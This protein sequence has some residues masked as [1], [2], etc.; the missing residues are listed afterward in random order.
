MNTCKKFIPYTVLALICLFN[1]WLALG[2]L[3]N[4]T[5]IS[6]NAKHIHYVCDMFAKIENGASLSEILRTPTYPPVFYINTA[7]WFKLFN[8]QNEYI[9]ILSIAPFFIISACS[10]YAIAKEYISSAAAFGCALTLLSLLTTSLLLDGYYIDYSLTAWIPLSFYFLTTKSKIPF[11]ARCFFIAF[12]LAMGLMC[13]WTFVSYIFSVIS[14]IGVLQILKILLNKRR[15]L[16]SPA[17]IKKALPAAAAVLLTSAFFIWFISLWYFPGSASG[18]GSLSFLQSYYVQS[19]AQE[20]QTVVGHFK[21]TLPVFIQRIPP[22]CMYLYILKTVL[23]IQ[24][25]ALLIF[26]AA[27]LLGAAF[28]PKR[29]CL[30]RLS[31]GLSSLTDSAPFAALLTVLLNTAVF[32]F[33][34]S[35]QLFE[36]ECTLRYVFPILPLLVFICF[37]PLSLMQEKGQK[38]LAAVYIT[39]AMTVLSSW[40]LP[41]EHF[42]KS[43]VFFTPGFNSIYETYMTTVSSFEDPLGLLTPPKS[44]RLEILG[45]KIAALAVSDAEKPAAAVCRLQNKEDF[46]PFLVILTHQTDSR[47]VIDLSLPGPPRWYNIKRFQ[48]YSSPVKS[49][50]KSCL[51]IERVSAINSAREEKYLN[52]TPRREIEAMLNRSIASAEYFSLLRSDLKETYVIYTFKN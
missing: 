7:L 21:H 18:G 30:R 22:L 25:Q 10:V 48:Y 39:A 43:P 15:A 35:P 46:D 12:S 52:I 45:R 14:V 29:L 16:P 5:L 23:P 40:A 50:P 32:S 1:T 19:R 9:A 2:F 37:A 36:P 4:S 26:G 44:S 17:Q 51:Y 34:P 38:L 31:F 8:T 41:K 24:L 49:Y 3:D 28:L 11:A 20:I 47:Y 13:K 33:Y 6:E 27:L 42:L